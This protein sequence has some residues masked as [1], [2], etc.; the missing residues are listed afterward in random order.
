LQ[1]ETQKRQV[2]CDAWMLATDLLDDIG[3]DPTN[4]VNASEAEYALMVLLFLSIQVSFLQW[5]FLKV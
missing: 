4:R 5:E 2:L 3:I 1:E